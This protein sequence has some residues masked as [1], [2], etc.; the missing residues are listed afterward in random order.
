MRSL[1]YLRGYYLIRRH[2]AILPN[3]SRRHGDFGGFA[4][5]TKLQ[6]A[7]KLKS[8]T[9]K[10]IRLLL[11]LK[12]QVALHKRKAPLEDFLATVLCPIHRQK[13]PAAQLLCLKQINPPFF[14]PT[15]ASL[16]LHVC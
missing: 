10:I 8:E 7:S 14:N 4:H 13:L 9:P 6:A 15:A 12:C 3:Q 16:V 2:F 11:F 5:K 1:R